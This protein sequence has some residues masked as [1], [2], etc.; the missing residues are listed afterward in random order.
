MKIAK[1]TSKA[2]RKGL[3]V[4]V[5]VPAKGRVKVTATAGGRKV[6]SG[7]ANAK[8]AGKVTVKLTKVKKSLK[9][10]TLT[11]K[12]TFNGDVTTKK[13]KVR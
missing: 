6:A 10:K 8:Q 3:A 12:L 13:L 11:L 2:L 9:G 1:A 4:T 5:E 7:S